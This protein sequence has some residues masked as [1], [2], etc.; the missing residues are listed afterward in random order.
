MPSAMMQ[1]WYSGI[2]S[3]V[4][5]SHVD[6][7]RHVPGSGCCCGHTSVEKL[8]TL[9]LVW[10]QLAPQQRVN[11]HSNR[12]LVADVWVGSVRG[13]EGWRAIQDNRAIFIWVMEW[14]SDGRA[15]NAK[16]APR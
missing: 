1:P 8:N 12:V 13:R 14:P 15:T 3:P 9:D 2:F 10:P 7:A 5:P 6:L 16:P 4:T 11:D